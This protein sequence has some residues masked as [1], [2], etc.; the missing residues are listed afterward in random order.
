M[1]LLLNKSIL[2]EHKALVQHPHEEKKAT[3]CSVSYIS[4]VYH[5][6]L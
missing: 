4:W 6:S 1:E 5:K 2:E 3:I